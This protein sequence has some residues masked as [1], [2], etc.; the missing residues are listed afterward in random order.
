MPQVA[1]V[2]QVNSR[3]IQIFYFLFFKKANQVYIDL[4][5]LRYLRQMRIIL[6]WAL[7]KSMT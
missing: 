3:S 6:I 5:Y 1:R 4:R 7:I 2:A